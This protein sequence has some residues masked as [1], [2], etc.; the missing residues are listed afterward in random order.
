MYFLLYS[1][2]LLIIL[3]NTPSPIFHL[4]IDSLR[5]STFVRVISLVLDILFLSLNMPR[6]FILLPFLRFSLFVGFYP[7][8]LE[9]YFYSRASSAFHSF[10][11]RPF[12]FPMLILK[13]F[14]FQNFFRLQRLRKL[15]LSDNEIHRLPPDIQNF[16]NLVE[17]DVSR[18]GEFVTPKTNASLQ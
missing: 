17:L 16:E 1:H 8:F 6:S 3:H 7:S 13:R 18:N 15:G 9:W 4:L 12:V 2:Q 5:C 11:H 14:L 10:C